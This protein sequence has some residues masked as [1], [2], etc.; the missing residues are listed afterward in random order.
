[1]VLQ[2]RIISLSVLIPINNSAMF[3]FRSLYPLLRNVDIFWIFFNANEV[4]SEFFTDDRNGSDTR[5]G[6]KNEIVF[7]GT[8]QNNQ[9]ETAIL[10]RWKYIK[11]IGKVKPIRLKRFCRLRWSVVIVVRWL[12]VSCSVILPQRVQRRRREN[13]VVFPSCS[14]RTLYAVCVF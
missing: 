4:S 8:R 2:I 12:R 6:V 3:L 9:I 7:M 5:K 10:T 14:Q 13:N 1:M 11:R